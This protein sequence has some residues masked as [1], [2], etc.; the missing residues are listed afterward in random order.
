MKVEIPVRNV[1]PGTV[2]VVV[3]ADGTEEIVRT[4]VVTKNGVALELTGSATV[5]VYDNSKFYPTPIPVHDEKWAYKPERTCKN[6]AHAHQLAPHEYACDA[7][8][9][10]I[11]TLSC[12]QPRDE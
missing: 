12:F 10:D 8:D 6:C 2:V 9:Y 4:S 5:K 11:D 7:G 3:H 1:T